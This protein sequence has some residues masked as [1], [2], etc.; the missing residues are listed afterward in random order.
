[1][2]IDWRDKIPP[3]FS[4]MRV[5]EAFLQTPRKNIEDV[6]NHIEND[7]VSPQ[8]FLEKGIGFCLIKDTLIVSQC[9]TDCVSGNKCE[10]GIRTDSEYRRRGLAT[11]TVAATVEYCLKAHFTHIGWH[12]G[13]INSGSI[14]TAEKEGFK[15]LKD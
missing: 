4:I 12:T 14:K 3:G 15:K 10:I 8:K 1:M 2:Y 13:I 7:C 9:L 11:I 6:L 5:D